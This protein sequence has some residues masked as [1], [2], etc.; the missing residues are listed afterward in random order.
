MEKYSV[1]VAWWS[2][3]VSQD[4]IKPRKHACCAYA[5]AYAFAYA[6]ASNNSQSV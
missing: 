5:Y 3:I 1:Y 4:I 2:S 6:C